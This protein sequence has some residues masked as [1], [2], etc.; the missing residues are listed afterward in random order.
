VRT[1]LASGDF[2]APS[3]HTDPMTDATTELTK[4]YI[5]QLISSEGIQAEDSKLLGSFRSVSSSC[6]QR[7]NALQT[8]SSTTVP[9]G[10]LDATTATFSHELG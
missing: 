9:H 2:S 4:E 8:S 3:R 7:I 6:I 1:L 5:I 10:S